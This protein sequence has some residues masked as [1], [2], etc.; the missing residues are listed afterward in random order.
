MKLQI[1]K[2]QCILCD[3]NGI[4]SCQHL[5]LC[6]PWTKEFLRCISTR[7]VT[8]Y[9]PVSIKSLYRWL[10]K[11]KDCN[12][13]R[14]LFSAI[15]GVVIYYTWISRCKKFHGDTSWSVDTCIERTK[16]EIKVS[17]GSYIERK[18]KCNREILEKLRL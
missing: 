4:D 16:T 15:Y 8:S 6:C 17:L 14:R 11:L 7:L 9:I 3:T 2:P 5:F 12:D 13:V 1:L 18:R 10:K